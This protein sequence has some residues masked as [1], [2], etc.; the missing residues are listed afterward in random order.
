[1]TTQ[2]TILYTKAVNYIQNCELNGR[3][4]SNLSSTNTYDTPV[5]AKLER[6]WAIVKKYSK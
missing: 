3:T 2:Q 4:I 6:A 1:M 5:L